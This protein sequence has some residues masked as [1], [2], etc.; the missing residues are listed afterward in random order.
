MYCPF[1]KS[2]FSKVI[3]T[4]KNKTDRQITRRRNCAKCNLRFSTKEIV[5]DEAKNKESRRESGKS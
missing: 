3:E 1:C 2:E 5:K 4:Y